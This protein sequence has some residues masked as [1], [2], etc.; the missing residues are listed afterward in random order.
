MD[1]AT[2]AVYERRAREWVERRTPQHADA[3]RAL[4]RAVRPDG[5]R[6][7]VGC[8]PGWYT[9]ELGR[10]AVALDAAAAMLDLVP[11]AAPAA[12]RVQA[13][14]ELLPFRA[15]SV[16]GAL[17]RASYVHV[18]RVRLPLALAE[19]HRAMEPDGVAE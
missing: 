1:P 4:G 12:M 19:L 6:L 17:A 18:P 8:G 16:A 5:V 10:P 7:D 9:A 14:L 15:R 3:A 2:V 13:D 11:S